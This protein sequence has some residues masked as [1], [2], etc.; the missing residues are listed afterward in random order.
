MKVTYTSRDGRFV[1]EFEGR[2]QTDLFEQIAA[3]QEVFENNVCTAK[4]NGEVVSS[5]KVRFVVRENKDGDKF[6]EKV[7]EDWD[8][9]LF[10]FKKSFGCRKT[11]QGTLF[12]KE[13]PEENR[14]P[15]LNG[16]HRYVKDENKNEKKE[17]KTSQ[18]KEEVPF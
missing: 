4:L 14:I 13:M 6:Y 3:F 11:P 1:A 16:W 17:S 10:G 15:G 2:T 9:K 12:P 5:D 18:T 7:C 8:K